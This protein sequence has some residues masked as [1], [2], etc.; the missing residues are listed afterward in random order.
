VIA[1]DGSVTGI[2]HFEIV[3]LPSLRA[4]TVTAAE[5]SIDGGTLC[6]DDTT[7][8]EVVTCG[9]GASQ[10]WAYQAAGGPNSASTLIIGNK[11]LEATGSTAALF[12]CNGTASQHWEFDPIG[13]GSGLTTVAASAFVNLASG[14]CL[15]A[16]NL[17]SGAAVAVKPCSGSINQ[18]WTSPAG[19]LIS[20][21]GT[22][23]GL[24]L[25]SSG[26]PATQVSVAS[27]DGSAG[28]KWTLAGDG[29]IRDS[30]GLCLDGN[31]SALDAT[32][33]VVGTCSQSFPQAFSQLWVPWA[34]GQLINVLSGRCLAHEGPGTGLVQE[35]CYGQAGEIWGIN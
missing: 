34:D 28:Q 7:G 11:C 15:A 26:S 12:T 22:G 14:R 31:N 4:S 20:G 6:L 17:V 9:G 27:C 18:A 10:L 8:V 1:K 30:G 23:S 21:A 13:A 16:P 35:D 33:I 3:V 5:M 2:T 32:S 25:H 29:T 24:C 19:P